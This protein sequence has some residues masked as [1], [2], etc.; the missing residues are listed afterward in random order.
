MSQNQDPKRI[1]RRRIE[2]G[3]SQTALAQKAGVTK[4]HLCSVENGK[5]GFSPEFLSRIAGALH[6]EIADLMPED[7]TAGAAR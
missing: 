7:D 5:A 6:C 4:S 2:A 3:L 1:R